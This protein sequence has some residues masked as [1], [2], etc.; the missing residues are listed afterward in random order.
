M[1]MET[2]LIL[3]QRERLKL[4]PGVPEPE[5][6]VVQL[7]LLILRREEVVDVADLTVP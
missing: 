3:D 5:V 7:F 1:E 6:V 2:H 4:R